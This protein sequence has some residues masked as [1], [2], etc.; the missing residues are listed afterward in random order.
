LWEII[1]LLSN[2]RF[3]AFAYHLHIAQEMEEKRWGVKICKENA[4]Q[5]IVA[6]R[7]I[8]IIPFNPAI[9]GLK[10]PRQIPVQQD[11]TPV[12]SLDLT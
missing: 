10:L 9:D 5:I 2:Q 6:H 8:P 11:D 1:S 4:K 7:K 12:S 3:F